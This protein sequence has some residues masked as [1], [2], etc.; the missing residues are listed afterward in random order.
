MGWQVMY[1][2]MAMDVETFPYIM[3]MVMLLGCYF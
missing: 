2:G 1:E 3:A